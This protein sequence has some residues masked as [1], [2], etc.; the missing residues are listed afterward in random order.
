MSDFKLVEFD[1]SLEEID[2]EWTVN[3]VTIQWSPY[4]SNVAKSW[5]I[6]GTFELI[7]EQPVE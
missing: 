5:E 6:E 3:L 4:P 7:Q 2:Y 1:G